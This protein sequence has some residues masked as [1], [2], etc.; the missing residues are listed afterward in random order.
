M[1]KIERG[2]EEQIRNAI[3]EG[4]FDNL[5]GAGQPL[6]LDAYFQAPEHLRMCYSILKNGNF[7][8]EEAQLLKDVE[9][10]RGQLAA[11]PDEEQRLKLTKAIGEKTLSFALLME[12]NK[13]AK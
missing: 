8:P 4:K 6:D 12:K 13:R 7:V 10:L 11:C 2:I 5:P 3:A 9:A 1:S